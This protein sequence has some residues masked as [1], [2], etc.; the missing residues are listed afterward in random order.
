MLKSLWKL[1]GQTLGENVVLVSVD[2]QL[3]VDFVYNTSN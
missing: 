2:I 3:R 1:K